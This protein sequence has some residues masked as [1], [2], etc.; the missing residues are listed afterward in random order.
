[1]HTT[2]NTIAAIVATLALAFGFTAA[3]QAPAQAGALC[4]LS[5]GTICGDLRH[6]TPDYGDDGPILA[7]CN[8]GNPWAA[9]VWVAEGRDAPCHDTD[10]LWVEYGTV[11]TCTW[12]GDGYGSATLHHTGSWVKIYDN[13]N[14]KCV[15]G[16]S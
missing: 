2:R 1:M 7:T 11:V 4:T 15:K 16:T 10:G 9:A 6:S 3:V 5:G 12:S 13:M 14:W 8:L